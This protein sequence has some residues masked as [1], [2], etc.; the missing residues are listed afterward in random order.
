MNNDRQEERREHGAAAEPGDCGHRSE[1]RPGPDGTPRPHYDGPRTTE[2][3]LVREWQV[4][5]ER[6]CGEL[7][8]EILKEKLRKTWGKSLEKV[9]GEVDRLMWKDWELSRKDGDHCAEREALVKELA[10]KIM[11]SYAQGPRR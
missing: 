6:A 10:K 7:R 4:A 5:Y 11:D 8:V 9:A 1:R 2:E 3:Y